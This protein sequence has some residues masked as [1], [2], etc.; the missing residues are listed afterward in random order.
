MKKCVIYVKSKTETPPNQPVCEC[1]LLYIYVCG[2]AYSCSSYFSYNDAVRT[3]VEI[4]STDTGPQI[5]LKQNM[6]HSLTESWGTPQNR[7]K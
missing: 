6:L 5:L 7:V 3:D 1:I 2:Y 4:S